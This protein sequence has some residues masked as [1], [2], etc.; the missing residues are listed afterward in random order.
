MCQL[1]AKH[2]TPIKAAAYNATRSIGLCRVQCVMAKAGARVCTSYAAD[3]GRIKTIDAGL[4]RLT[5]S[6]AAS[7]VSIYRLD[8]FY[9]GYEDKLI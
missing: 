4:H 5:N 1:S 2:V 9:P 7:S 6:T 3:D 8:L